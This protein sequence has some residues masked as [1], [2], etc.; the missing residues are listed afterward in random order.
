MEE[1]SPRGQLEGL[2]QQAFTGIFW[3]ADFPNHYAGPAT[4]ATAE[5]GNLVIEAETAAL[6]EVLRAV[7]KDRATLPLQQAFY[8][9][10]ESPLT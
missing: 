10:S 1:A 5:L 7:K 3:Y 2:D 6:V 4:E 8:D 9:H